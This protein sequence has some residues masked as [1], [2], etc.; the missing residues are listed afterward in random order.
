MPQTGT[1][2]IQAQAWQG[3]KGDLLGIVQMVTIWPYWQNKNC[4]RKKTRCTKL[5]G[6]L[7]EK[8]ITQS[9]SENQ[10]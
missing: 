6:T 10:I 2:G 1:E 3:S 9:W 8:Q 5:S 4:S 7:R